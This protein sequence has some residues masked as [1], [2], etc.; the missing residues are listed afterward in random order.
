MSLKSSFSHHFEGGHI[1]YSY[2][3]SLIFITR[4]FVASSSAS[5][6]EMIKIW[7]HRGFKLVT[8]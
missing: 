4:P 1:N 2:R 3:Q 5:Y 7:L 6:G 8:R